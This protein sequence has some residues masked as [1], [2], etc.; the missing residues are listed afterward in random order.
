MNRKYMYQFDNFVKE[1]LNDNRV[2]YD[3][4]SV[5]A[6]HIETGTE[7]GYF[8][9]VPLAPSKGVVYANTNKIILTEKGKV[10]AEFLML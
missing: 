6:K 4:G 3:N 1:L 5:V 2:Q 8:Y 9:T 10:Y 7:K